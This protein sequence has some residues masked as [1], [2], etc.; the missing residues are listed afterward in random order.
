METDSNP[1]QSKNS[2]SF[3]AI[4]VPMN[5]DGTIPEHTKQLIIQHLQPEVQDKIDDII[6]LGKSALAYYH[7]HIDSYQDLNL[8]FVSLWTEARYVE[9][10]KDITFLNE[11]QYQNRGIHTFT[12]V[13]LT[14]EMM[15]PSTSVNHHI[16]K[17]A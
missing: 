10:K 7:I 17:S 4:Y 8:I 16:S 14:P 6:S 1:M 3:K 15:T 11:T 13:I 9:F 2:K 12:S 5:S